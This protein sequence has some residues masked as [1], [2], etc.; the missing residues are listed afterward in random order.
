MS[1]QLPKPIDTY[2][3][4]ENAGDM[5]TLTACFASDAVVHDEGRTIQGHAA[6]REWMSGSR[7]KYHHTVEPVAVTTKNV[8]IVMTG[9]VSGT[10][11]NSPVN[12]N[13]NFGVTDG[14]I[15]SLEIG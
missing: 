13:F 5:D 12:L 6:I 8:K 3:A 4:S 14:K 11:P 7:E 9:K 2:I 15:S 1:V 10:F